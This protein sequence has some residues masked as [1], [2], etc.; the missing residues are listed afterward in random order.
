MKKYIE[1]SKI[2]LKKIIV[3]NDIPP[4]YHG[5]VTKINEI[6]IPKSSL[7]LYVRNFDAII[8]PIIVPVIAYIKLALPWSISN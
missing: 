3:K 1:S 6:P 8:A 7:H 2:V 5:T 4:P